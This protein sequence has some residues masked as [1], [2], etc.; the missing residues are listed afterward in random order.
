MEDFRG[1]L[2]Q[3][4]TTVGSIAA[5]GAVR[6]TLTARTQFTGGG[7]FGIPTGT[8]IDRD[9]Y[10]ISLTA[11]TLYRIALTSSPAAAG[12]DG[13]GDPVVAIYDAAG[14]ILA[15]NDNAN[16]LTKN[17]LL[18]FTPATGGT[19]FIEVRSARE[20]RSIV[21]TDPAL[22]PGDYA[23]RVAQGADPLPAV[24]PE[25]LLGTNG[26]D[27]LSGSSTQE[28]FALGGNDV[29]NGFNPLTLPLPGGGLG[30]FIL[31]GR[32]TLYG[33]DGADSI[34]GNGDDDRLYGDAGDD[35]IDGGAD[36][37]SLY[38]GS[39][40]D[41]MLG[42]SGN[43]LIEGGA[44][45]DFIGGGSGNDTIR[46]DA[47]NDTIYAGLGDDNVG[48]GDGNDLIYGS[49]GTNDLWGGNGDDTVH[50]G[51]GNERIYGGAGRN[52]LFGNGGND[53]ITGG[54]DG[55][56]IGGGAGNDTIRGGSGND[57]IYAG[58]GND[59]A[60]GGGGNDVIYASG[61]N[62]TLWG[63]LGNDTLHA[64][65]G[66]DLMNGGPGADVFVF[67][68]A[69]AIGIGAGRDVIT[70][71]TPGTDDIDLRALGT[72]FNGGA[73]LVGGGA[74]S[75]YYFASGGL[76]I[77]DQTGDGVAGWVLELAGAPAV[78]AGDFLL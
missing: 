64:G 47:G 23:L 35:T 41:S 61:G 10:S 21:S 68:S 1:D 59:D 54:N 14:T 74:K 16:I 44:D 69:A 73:G 34:R 28:V 19:Y 37:D 30:T 63:G 58:L 32:D 38:G 43:D 2:S 42:D 24:P 22:E 8:L 56:L 5:G 55:D 67:A 3:D 71:F 60:A 9:W 17:S 77:G 45:A 6:G 66:K 11:G 57:T 70:G 33:G 50:G 25:M 26:A 72:S 7:P 36:N 51:S 12:R 53:S 15:S 13:L 31:H 46:G 27:T 76:L 48:G 78:G 52:Q 75:F 39:G 4:V 49:G 20:F 18:S 40:D 29:M 62:S 65:T